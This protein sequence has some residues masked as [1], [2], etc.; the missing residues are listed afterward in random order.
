MLVE[1]RL[2]I[3]I[4]LASEEATSHC[5]IPKDQSI[6]KYVHIRARCCQDSGVSDKLIQ[7]PF[8]G[9]LKLFNKGWLDVIV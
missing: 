8:R 7:I 2:V 1:V 6:C 3:H 5:L 4:F 9:K